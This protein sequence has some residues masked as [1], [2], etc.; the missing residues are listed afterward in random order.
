MDY[1]DLKVLQVMAGG[2]HGGAE[3]AFIDMCIA[4]KEMGVHIHV[5]TRSQKDRVQ[6]LVDH[7]IPVTIMRF[8]SKLDLLT[9]FKMKK[10]IKAFQPHIVQSWMSRASSFIPDAPIEENGRKSY[11]K[12]CRLGGYYKLKYF[13]GFDRF[14]VIAPDIG[15]YLA[16]EGVPANKIVHINNFAETESFE[17][18]ID[19]AELHTPEDAPVFLSLSRLH[20]AKA[21]DVF[22]KAAAK[23]PD[24]YLWLAGEGPDREDLE[25]LAKELGVDDRV[26]FLGWRTDRAALL[27]AADYCCFPSRHEPFGTVFVQAWMNEV[28]LVVSRA[29]GPSQFVHDGEDGLMFDIDD[30]DGLATHMQ[31]MID[32]PELCRGLIKNGYQ[33]YLNEF[34]KEQS[35][36][37]YLDLY[38]SKLN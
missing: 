19:R 14:V 37:A 8:G 29:Q 1:K 20:D 2:E 21:L 27:D 11:L 35:V 24:A 12:F 16:E 6:R 26:R 3:T 9:P 38:L 17:K 31:S 22:L 15:R 18:P 28:P 13:Q 23:V 36:Q 34:T 25:N 5:A 33:R 32:D 10:L 4:M 7:D 30:V